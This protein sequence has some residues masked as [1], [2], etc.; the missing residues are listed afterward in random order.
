MVQLC[1]V[2]QENGKE[3]IEHQS[4]DK[5]KRFDLVKKYHDLM[6]LNVTSFSMVIIQ[7]TF[8]FAMHV[9][10]FMFLLFLCTSSKII[11]KFEL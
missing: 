10:Q 4:N 5:E 9:L 8:A 6:C 2:I 1:F 3:S 11:F 7:Q